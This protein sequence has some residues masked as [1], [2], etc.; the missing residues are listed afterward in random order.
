MGKMDQVAKEGRTVLF[1]SHNTAAIQ[2]LCQ[3]GII[4]AEGRVLMDMSAKEAVRYYT[5]SFMDRSALKLTARRDRLGDGKLRFTDVW[6]EDANGNRIWKIIGGQ[7]VRFCF[8]YKAESELYNF[9]I[10][11]LFLDSFCHIF[12]RHSSWINS[13]FFE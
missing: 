10:C 6:M 5:E 13:N 2:A 1:V 9:H 7:N 12:N 11:S 8:A 3:R 4:L